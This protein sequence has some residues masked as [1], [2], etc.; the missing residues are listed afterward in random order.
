MTTPNSEEQ[1]T[2]RSKIVERIRKCFAKGDASRNSSE[3]EVQTALDAAHRLMKEHNIA[4]T[5]VQFNSQ[6]HTLNQKMG[7]SEATNKDAPRINAYES[8]LVHVVSIL[9]DGKNFYQTKWVGFKKERVLIFVGLKDDIEIAKE[10]LEDLI[11][12]VDYLKSEIGGTR[13]DKLAFCQGVAARLYD[14]AKA[15][16]QAPNQY[17]NNPSTTALM[18]VKSQEVERYYNRLN[19]GSSR[20]KSHIR[21]NSYYNEGYKAGNNVPLQPGVR[22]IGDE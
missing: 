7:E 2:L 19:L 14:R 11:N 13:T 20:V 16:K 1:K 18:V 22:K 10:F 15:L 6:T 5:E 4:E 17:P 21:S 8:R 12:A 9:C 3:A